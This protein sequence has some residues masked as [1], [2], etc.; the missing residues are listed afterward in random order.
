MTDEFLIDP[1]ATSLSMVLQH[2]DRPLPS[3]LRSDPRHVEPVRIEIDADTNAVRETVEQLRAELLEAY[4]FVPREI[5]VTEAAGGWR[6]VID[7]EVVESSTTIGRDARVDLSGALSRNLW[8]MLRIDDTAELV[9][10]ARVASPV[11]IDRAMPHNLT[12]EQLH[13]VLYRLLRDGLPIK[14]L[15]RIVEVLA[16]AP[17]HQRD[18]ASLVS[19]ARLSRRRSIVERCRQSDGALRVVALSVGATNACHHLAVDPVQ[20]GDRRD[21]FLARIRR[22][23]RSAI[24]EHRLAPCVVACEPI[25]RATVAVALRELDVFVVSRAELVGYDVER[26]SVLGDGIVVPV[27]DPVGPQPPPG[28]EGADWNWGTPSVGSHAVRPTGY[29]DVVDVE[30]ID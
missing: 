19:R 18:T 10:F 13:R 27:P 15:D 3:E 25:A 28:V 7:G 1:D 30:V 20:P 11:A 14:P 24:A 4:G 29:V 6:L 17:H 16:E 23:V 26:V 12:I 21:R 9:A 2:G 8:R 22:D 5:D